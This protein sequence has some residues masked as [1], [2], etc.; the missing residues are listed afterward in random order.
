MFHKSA[1]LGC[2]LLIGACHTETSGTSMISV[3]GGGD[4]GAGG[5]TEAGGT[6]G[7]GGNTPPGMC[8][9]DPVPACAN[10]SNFTDWC[11]Y[12]GAG[13]FPATSCTNCEPKECTHQFGPTPACFDSALWCCTY[14]FNPAPQPKTFHCVGGVACEV[15]EDIFDVLCTYDED[16]V[17]LDSTA[18]MLL[19]LKECRKKYPQYSCGLWDLVCD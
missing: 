11:T 8:Q 5:V 18:A 4:G 12:Y 1:L 19:L 17:A 7:A 15:G 3:G 14:D 9:C 13:P 2:L 10:P 16:V 6:A